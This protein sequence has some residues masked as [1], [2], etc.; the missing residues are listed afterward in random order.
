MLPPG[1]FENALLVAH[2]ATLPH[3]IDQTN[4]EVPDEVDKETV[5]D[6]ACS[7]ETQAR[8]SEKADRI[9]EV[10]LRLWEQLKL[11]VKMGMYRVILHVSKLKMAPF[12]SCMLH[13]ACIENAICHMPSIAAQDAQAMA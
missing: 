12:S 8:M 5:D 9:R 3:A 13:V 1:L 10:L 2:F 11:L 4:S 6:E 7:E